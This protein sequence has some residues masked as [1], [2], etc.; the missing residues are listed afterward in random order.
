MHLMIKLY[1]NSFLHNLE[2]DQI[3]TYFIYYI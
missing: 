3:I 2:S 1:F